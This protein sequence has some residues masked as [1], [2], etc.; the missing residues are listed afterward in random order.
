MID[1]MTLQ[2]LMRLSPKMVIYHVKR[3]L[4]NKLSARFPAAYARHIDRVMA[5]VPDLGPCRGHQAMALDVARFYDEVYASK[6]PGAALGRF[7]FL[8]QEVD[9]GAASSVDWH[10]KVPAEKDFHLWRQKLG[11]MGFICPMLIRGDAAQLAGV[12]DLIEGFREQAD[13]GRAEC[14]TSVWF[15]YSASH[16]ILAI[17]S[18]YLIA[19]ESRDL[20]KD[21][22]NRIEAFLRWNAAFV[23]A[24]IEH[25]LKNNHVER[26]L[27]AL[28]FYYTHAQTVPGAIA[29]RLDRD[30][31]GLI[32]E[33]ILPDGL[34]AERSAM[35]QGLSVMALQVFVQSPFL[36][37]GTIALAKDRLQQA[38]RAWRIMT[39]PDGEI[40]L[41]NDS[42]FGEVPCPADLLAEADFAP[43]EVLPDAGYGRFHQGDI[44]ALFDAGPIG[45]SW[46]P[47]HGHAD[48]L[49]VEVDVAGHRFIVD[50][51]TYQYS[52]GSRR[53]HDRAAASHNG[54][55]IIG[56]EPVS[57]SGAFRVGTLARARLWSEDS[58]K[59]TLVAELDVGSGVLR[60]QVTL[61]GEALYIQDSWPTSPL[62]GRVRLLVPHYWRIVSQDART[63][64]FARDGI[65]ATLDVTSGKVAAVTGGHWSCRYLQDLTAHAIDLVPPENASLQWNV[66]RRQ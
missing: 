53:M 29:R 45:P 34:S 37:L 66:S 5:R 50:P 57:Y 6:A 54:P 33:T 20:P 3:V 59:G 44:F 39:H 64:A 10:H 32:R 60:R 15:P 31:A 21:L 11:H 43:C 12:A 42:W 38:Q 23:L 56:H 26:N 36:S 8:A 4:R 22:Q 41:F 40:A 16:R 28:C 19:R 13:F 9:F 51:G 63:I 65:K 2:A 61:S 48:F 49:S 62:A 58:S 1:K 7:S 52:T 24:N 30:V 35:Y 47:G 55:S 46:N 18:G 14:Y 27:A 17:L 25:E